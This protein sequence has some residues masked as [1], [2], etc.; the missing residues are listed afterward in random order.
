MTNSG[1]FE[2]LH[3]F[4]E[5]GDGALPSGRLV[6]TADGTIF[7]TTLLGGASGGGTIFRITTDLHYT[8]LH[9]FSTGD[10]STPD[11]GLVLG[12]DGALYGTAN[13]TFFRT[14]PDGD[15]SVIRANDGS[16]NSVFAGLTLG[17]DGSFYTTTQSGGSASAGT[18]VRVNGGTGTIALLHEFTGGPEGFDSNGPLLQGPDGSLYGAT[19]GGGLKGL[20]TLFVT[21]PTG[22]FTTIHSFNGDDG[23][24]PAGALIRATDGN[25]YGAT[26]A[27]GAANLG[28]IF[29]MDASSGAVTV[30]HA[31]AG[32]AD[33]SGPT[34][35]LVQ[36]TD[37]NF[38]GATAAGG[39]FNRGTTFRITLGGTLTILHSF[40]G[41]TDGIQPASGLLQGI[42]GNFYGVTLSSA[43]EEYGT[44]YR[45]TPDGTLTTV[46][47]LYRHDGDYSLVGVNGLVRA[48][49]GF[50][51]GTT[52]G[53]KGS[54][55]TFFRIAPDGAVTVLHE[56]ATDRESPRGTLV[57]ASDGNFYGAFGGTLSRLTPGGALTVLHTTNY[58]TAEGCCLGD[59]L[60]Q[61]AD[62]NF[63][64]T[65]SSGGPYRA[66]R[67]FVSS[68]ARRSRPRISTSRPRATAP[69]G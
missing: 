3:T 35:A 16:P 54:L 22:R 49:D 34:G 53:L 7:G 55:G 47:Q 26:S 37:G 45:M 28:T 42:D 50:L 66:A 6:Q 1:F 43:N 9:S 38:Y 56:F 23:T 44:A 65:A 61:T 18:V 52:Q 24:S 39:T 32:G 36:G 62:G 14:T 10:G 8:L 33:G 13:G 67:C 11:A 31:F 2:T 58:Y 59:S 27:G 5:D 4:A 46:H 60:I 64:G 17:R 19:S 41:T 40:A 12:N 25:F 30:L 48:R 57:E 15:F 63:Y 69:S 68:P 20:G 51:Y 29:R 21:T